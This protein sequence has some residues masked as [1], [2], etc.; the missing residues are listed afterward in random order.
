MVRSAVEPLDEVREAVVADPTFRQRRSAVAGRQVAI[1]AEL[2]E[3][4]LAVVVIPAFTLLHPRLGWSQLDSGEVGAL[5]RQS[6]VVR[7][8]MSLP[9]G[10]TSPAELSSVELGVVYRVCRGPSRL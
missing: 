6:P 8:A 4:E 3:P 5:I 2:G 9:D 1:G 10:L 7:H